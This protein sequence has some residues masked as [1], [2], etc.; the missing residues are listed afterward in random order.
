MSTWAI[1]CTNCNNEI[2]SA[3]PMAILRVAPQ[4]T[5]GKYVLDTVKEALCEECCK[6]QCDAP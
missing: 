2:G 1:L 5:V 4:M 3:Q 6:E